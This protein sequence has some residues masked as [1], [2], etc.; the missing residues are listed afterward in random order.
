VHFSPRSSKELKKKKEKEIGFPH[1]RARHLTAWLTLT[2][3]LNAKPD[4]T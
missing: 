1:N 3:T 2:L 4:L